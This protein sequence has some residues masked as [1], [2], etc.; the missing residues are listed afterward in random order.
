MA[1]PLDRLMTVLR[2][3]VLIFELQ[4]YTNINI[5]RTHARTQH[6]G[7]Q[8]IVTSRARRV[9]AEAA[10][11]PASRH[12]RRLLLLPT[13]CRPSYIHVCTCVCV[14][15]AGID[16]NQYRMYCCSCCVVLCCAHGWRRIVLYNDVYDD[17]IDDDDDDDVDDNSSNNYCVSDD[18][19]L[20]E[21]GKKKCKKKKKIKVN[22]RFY[23]AR[24]RHNIVVA[25]YYNIVR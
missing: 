20:R 21:K 10:S 23:R 8:C 16:E 14:Y 3:F 7:Q 1:A 12:C 22:K 25:H 24:R 15:T 19:R 2:Y 9:I 13:T 17:D 5:T 6:T 11:S 4:T 18:G